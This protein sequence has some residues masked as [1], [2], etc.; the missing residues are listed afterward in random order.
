MSSA[1]DA[2]SITSLWLILR[3]DCGARIAAVPPPGT[4]IVRTH[5]ACGDPSATHEGG[6]RGGFKANSEIAMTF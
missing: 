1:I 4:E 3:L 5:Q 2:I 6:I